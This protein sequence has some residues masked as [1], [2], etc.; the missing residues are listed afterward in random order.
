MKLIID[1]IED[2]IAVCETEDGGRVEIASELL[3]EGACDGDVIEEIN[4]IY[5]VLPDE[6]D[7][8]RHK[9]REILKGLMKEGFI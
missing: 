2:G 5:C 3:P 7:A 1:R 9:I 6:T 8:R 4:G